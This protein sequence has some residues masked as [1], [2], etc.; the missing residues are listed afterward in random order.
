MMLDDFRYDAMLRVLRDI[1]T[2]IIRQ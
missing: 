2:I 1:D